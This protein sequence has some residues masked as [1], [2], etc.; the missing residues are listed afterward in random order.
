M[1]GAATGRPVRGLARDDASRRVARHCPGRR[2]AQSPDLPER[3]AAARLDSQASSRRR[4]PVHSAAICPSARARDT[5]GRPGR[6]PG[7]ANPESG[8]AEAEALAGASGE[9]R[10][11]RGTAHRLAHR[12]RRGREHRG[13]GVASGVA[14]RA[15]SD[16]QRI[17]GLAVT[18][19]VWDGGRGCE[20]LLPRRGG[21]R[22]RQPACALLRR[23]AAMSDDGPEAHVAGGRRR[24]APGRPTQRL[25]GYRAALRCRETRGGRPSGRRREDERG[26]GRSDRGPCAFASSDSAGHGRHRSMRRGTGAVRV[27]PCSGRP[28]GPAP[29][30]RSEIWLSSAESSTWGRGAGWRTAR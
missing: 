13:A 7:R 16:H 1:A 4:G 18:V 24:P 12:A 27:D 5:R 29:R 22:A 26:V 2:R 28:C 21:I 14:P 8:S 19:L 25:P 20:D 10:A 15:R 9:P 17:P 6:P 30:A 3:A 23:R 11:G